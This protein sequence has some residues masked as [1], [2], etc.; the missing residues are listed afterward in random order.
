MQAFRSVSLVRSA[1]TSVTSEA[2]G[3]RTPARV[4]WGCWVV[5]AWLVLDR[6]F[7]QLWVALGDPSAVL[8]MIGFGARQTLYCA[9]IGGTAVIT[10]WLNARI[11]RAVRQALGQRAVPL[12]LAAAALFTL[13]WFRG[14]GPLIAALSTLQVPKLPAFGEA[15]GRAASGVCGA[16][17]VVLGAFT[18]GDL[19]TSALGLPDASPGERQIIGATLGAG[20]LGV[21]S[22]VLAVA[23]IYRP[24]AVAVMIAGVFA[25][26]AVKRWLIAPPEPAE[27][28]PTLAPPAP[29]GLDK[30]WL[31][32][33]FIAL[34][35]AFVG[36]LA[37]E[38]EYDA[39]WYHLYFP[40]LWLQSGRPVDLIQEFPSLYPM[41]WELVY[42]AG[43]ALGGSVAAKL[44]HFACLLA[45]M[46]TVGL[47]C[48]R[49]WPSCSAY[50]AVGLLVT[51]PTMLWEATTAYNDLA[52]AMFASLA[53]YALARFAETDA[54][55]WLIA[56]GLEF[57]LAACTKH[58]GLIVLSVAVIV[59]AA[60]WLWRGRSFGRL[61]RV[62]P[63]L[64]LLTL[65]LPLP[66]YVRAWRRS[67]NP[68]FPE[69]YGIFGGGPA[70][71]WD[72]SANAGLAL[73][74]AHFGLGRGVWAL[75]RLPWDAT[76]HS[77]LFG[78][79][80]GPLWL[81]LIPGCLLGVRS[82][83]TAAALIA[84]TLGYVV[85]WASPISSFQLR[86]LVPVGSALALLAAGGWGR[87]IGPDSAIRA[88]ARQIAGVAILAVACLTLP[89]F[90]PLDEADRVGYS[91]WLTH[92]MRIAPVAV[93]TG[94]EF[95]A[96][97]LA[98]TVSSYSVWQYADTHL[99]AD[100][101]VLTFTGGDN[102]YSR[103]TRYPDSSALARPAVY[104]AKTD[105]D[106]ITALRNLRIDYVIFDR[107]LLPQLQ[108]D[109]LPIAGETIQRACTTLYQDKRYRLCQLPSPRSAGAAARPQPHAPRPRGSTS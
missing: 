52:V 85:I 46:G 25:V 65:A 61:L 90:V 50:V 86:F 89:P 31:W 45:L 97:Y 7:H 79:A 34:S 71:R 92:V 22:S 35:F 42:G 10:V 13:V 64:G 33:A 59:L 87:L 83:R 56:S 48:R 74:K 32:L 80:F 19:V 94:K 15:L 107:R 93:V 82:R 11:W 99:P 57:S 67:G 1:M 78:G 53:C 6:Y 68:F 58:L 30:A 55:S 73:F 43:L 108:S 14:H 8:G 4:L 76:V 36:A 2:R 95:E 104:G 54:W 47:T 109:H 40:H 17:L 16:A 21:C 77:A 96:Q 63:T 66:W 51:A 100:S 12:A 18:L 101:S 70:A 81:I 49:Y 102:L 88:S 27:P 29:A 20:A 60:Y 26:G 44:L 72:A 3:V 5:W 9:T 103:R 28:A 84:G 106:V 41:T 24:W 38:T 62:V 37:P 39:L 69:L 105:A 23:G 98:R 75:L 91:G